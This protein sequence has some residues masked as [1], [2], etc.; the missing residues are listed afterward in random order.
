MTGV[1]TNIV[2]SFVIPHTFYTPKPLSFSLDFKD[3]SKFGK[4]LKGP[5]FDHYQGPE[6]SVAIAS[7]WWRSRSFLR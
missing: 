2:V 7:Q 3:F 1:A 6:F 4:Y 5:E